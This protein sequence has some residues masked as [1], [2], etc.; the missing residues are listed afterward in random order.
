VQPGFGGPD[1]DLEGIGRLARRQAEVIGQYE[2]RLLWDGEPTQTAF[3]QVAVRQACCAIGL[4]RV[5][6]DDRDLGPPLSTMT[7]DVCAGSDDQPVQPGIESFDV[8]KRRQIAPGPYQCFLGRILREF[9]IPEGEPSDRVQTIDGAG[10]Q[11]AEGLTVSTSR[12]V[13]ELCLHAPLPSEATYLAA[14]HATAEGKADR[15]KDREWPGTRLPRLYY[16]PRSLETD[17]AVR[18]SLHAKCIVVDGREVFISSANFT[19]AA[20]HRNIEVGVLVQSGVLARQAT[21]FF[22]AMIRERVCLRLV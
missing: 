11:D 7:T 15:F 20:H 22:E 3:D 17:Q 4:R 2:D 12:P 16:D 13:D 19:E 1:R 6:P 14:L 21:E 9:G 18:T 8:A 10:R 5:I